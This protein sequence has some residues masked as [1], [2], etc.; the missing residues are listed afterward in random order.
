MHH[1]GHDSWCDRPNNAIHRVDTRSRPHPIEVHLTDNLSLFSCPCSIAAEKIE[2]M[3]LFGA[4]P[5]LCPPVPFSDP[6][7][8]Y[9]QAAQLEKE[10]DGAVWTNQV[11]RG[12]GQAGMLGSCVARHAWVFTLVLSF[13]VVAC[14]SR[15]SRTSAPTLKVRPPLQ[16]PHLRQLLKPFIIHRESPCLLLSVPD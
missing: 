11:S 6:K 1:P 10:I 13:C 14:S 2:S 16:F 9:Q 7:N 12:L 5:R 4:E 15:R 8:Y 3:A